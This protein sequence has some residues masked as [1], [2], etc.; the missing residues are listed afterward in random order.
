MK[1]APSMAANIGFQNRCEKT[2]INATGFT[3][4]GALIDK[5]QPSML[6]EL[7]PRIITPSIVA[8]P[9]VSPAG[10]GSLITICVHS[11]RLEHQRT[12]DPEKDPTTSGYAACL[13]VKAITPNNITSKAIP[14]D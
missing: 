6:C 14:E 5:T 2:K 11:A 4:Q 12:R 1:T 10:L 9:P 13:F 7:I 3:L 8:Q